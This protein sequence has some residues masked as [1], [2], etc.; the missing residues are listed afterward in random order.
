[1]QTKRENVKRYLEWMMIH[2]EFPVVEV[3]GFMNKDFV[4]GLSMPFFKKVVPHKGL[5]FKIT[6]YKI[7]VFKRELIFDMEAYVSIINICFVK[8]SSY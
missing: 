2:K 4:T 8:S 1:M 3:T 6:E 5:K 7:F